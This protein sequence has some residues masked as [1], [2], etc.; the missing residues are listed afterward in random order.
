LTVVVVLLR[1]GYEMD[2]V[3]KPT[4]GIGTRR[5]LWFRSK[6]LALIVK[7]IDKLTVVVVLLREG[8]EMDYV[9][10]PATGIERNEDHGISCTGTDKLEYLGDG[11]WSL[12]D[13]W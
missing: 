8:Y 13:R 11:L 2:Y 12:G 1:E 3:I 10:K 5:R 6:T 4:T 9:I 7:L